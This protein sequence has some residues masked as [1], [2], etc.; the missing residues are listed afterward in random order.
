MRR[1]ILYLCS[2][3]TLM[4]LVACGSSGG[5]STSINTPVPGGSV[6]TTLNIVKTTLNSNETTA[7]TANFMDNGKPYAGLPVTFSVTP[8]MATLNPANGQVTTDQ[9]G[10]T[11]TVYLTA[12]NTTGVAELTVSALINGANVTKTSPF[13]VNTQKL[14][15]A[16]PTYDKSSTIAGGGTTIVSVKILDENG[17]NYV[18]NDVDVYFGANKGYFITDNAVGKVRTYKNATGTETY[19][20]ATYSYAG[21]SVSSSITDSF[22]IT[23]GASTVTGYITIIPLQASSLQYI[24]S[25]PAKTT[26]GY[27]EATTLSFRVTDLRGTGLPKQSVNFSI[28]GG[29]A[30]SPS[31]KNLTGVTDSS[32]YVYTTVVAGSAPATMWITASL[33]DGSGVSAHSAVFS[34]I[35]TQTI[36]INTVS[37]VA[38]TT[39]ASSANLPISFK[40]V[41]ATGAGVVGQTVDFTVVDSMGNTSSAANLQKSSAVS[42]SQGLVTTTLVSG[43]AAAN[44]WVKATLRS[45]VTTFATTGMITIQSSAEGTVTLT[46]SSAA[47]RGGD[48]IMATVKFTSQSPPPYS[49][50]AVTIVS[51]DSSVISNTTGTTD[52][53]GNANIILDVKNVTGKTNLYAMIG[54]NLSPMV[55]LSSTSSSTTGGSLTLSINPSTPK[56]GDNITATVQYTNPGAATLE[57]IDVSI[58]PSPAGVISV[59]DSSKTDSTG[60]AI[61]V[62]NVSNSATQNTVVTLYAKTSST[63]S[64]TTLVTIGSAAQDAASLALSV[65]SA[66]STIFSSPTIVV[67]GN[68]AVFTTSQGV[69]LINQAVRISVDR[70]DNG[71]GSDSVSVNGTTLI[72]GST[73][74]ASLITDTT[75]TVLIPTIITCNP[76]AHTFIIY[77]RAEAT[78]PSSGKTVRA[79]GNT[80][81]SVT[82]A[83]LTVSPPTVTFAKPA[84]IGA[85]QTV[86]ISGGSAPYAASTTAPGDI[87]PTVSGTTLTLTKNVA[88][89]ATASTATITVLDN[90]GNQKTFT[91]TYFK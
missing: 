4:F 78:D 88:D 79:Y 42:D 86:T 34:V 39:I 62:L 63:V 17:N 73:N 16:T 1:Y 43:T 90:V 84:G 46:L 45:S 83:L 68:K 8:G 61:I 3:L 69:P 13:F 12:A 30:G 9:N 29:P 48:K 51:T 65:S 31:L 85:T 18:G 23:L 36:S 49:S 44:L 33:A 70:Y 74:S 21:A 41:D 76:T 60:K 64:P 66:H 47:P 87:D 25:L 38:A 37:P 91:V 22:T 6:T 59:V 71:T 57:G 20:S 82:P 52:S 10:N 80:A 32:G 58:V 11:P 2:L 19:A 15:L 24:S 14:K 56:P 26:L 35:P 40:V 81:V 53:L 77:W 54:N 67:Q 89:G 72:T 7:V 5:S 55:A 50:M 28:S 27:G 75:G